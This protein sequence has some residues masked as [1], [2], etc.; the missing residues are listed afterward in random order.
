MTSSVNMLCKNVFE[1][2]IQFINSRIRSL[3]EQ[4]YDDET[5][6]RLAQEEIWTLEENKKYLEK[7]VKELA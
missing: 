1:K 2:E 4:P 6:T 3:N 5:D 7:R